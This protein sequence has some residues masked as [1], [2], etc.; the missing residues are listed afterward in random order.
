MAVGRAGDGSFDAA[1]KAAHAGA[2]AGQHVAHS[3]P[4]VVDKRHLWRRNVPLHHRRAPGQPAAEPDKHNVVVRLQTP[5]AVKTSSVA[6]GTFR[7]DAVLPAAGT[8]RVQVSL[9]LSEFDNPVAIVTFN[10]AD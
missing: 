9:R 2:A 10:V 4:L 3:L 1:L 8:W 7:A 5:L 6:A